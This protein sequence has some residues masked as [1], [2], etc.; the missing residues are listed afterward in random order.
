MSLILEYKQYSL[1]GDVTLQYRYEFL[2]RNIYK[3]TIVKNNNTNTDLKWY[4]VYYLDTSKFKKYLTNDNSL[5]SEG[6]IRNGLWKIDQ[7]RNKYTFL[8]YS[9]YLGLESLKV[10]CSY[11][12]LI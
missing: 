8:N 1:N 6:V 7:I 11:F 4:T 9:Y 10:Q 3:A 5:I 2:D 12:S